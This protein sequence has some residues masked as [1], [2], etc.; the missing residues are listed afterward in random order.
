MLHPDQ[1]GGQQGKDAQMLTLIEDLKYDI[2]YSS[3]KDIINFGND[4]TSCYDWIIP[5]LASVFA[6]KKGLHKNF[7]LL[8]KPSTNVARHFRFMAQG[9]GVPTHQQSGSLSV[10][11]SSKY[12]NL[13]HTE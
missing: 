5:S 4:T 13:K 8:L 7:W 6:Q 9:K 12:T 1:F 3:R 10:Q 11:H 2:S